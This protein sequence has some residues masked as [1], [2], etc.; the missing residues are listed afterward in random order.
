MNPFSISPLDIL[1]IVAVVPDSAP[2]IVSDAWNGA[3]VEVFS[4]TTEA[5]ELLV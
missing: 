3:A 2:V 4:Y 5:P 1:W